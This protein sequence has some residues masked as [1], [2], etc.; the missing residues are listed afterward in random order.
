MPTGAQSTAL[1]RAVLCF[2]SHCQR[3]QDLYEAC[4]KY[5]QPIA[6][7]FVPHFVPTLMPGRATLVGG[8]SALPDCGTTDCCPQ[9]L[10]EGADCA[11]RRAERVAASETVFD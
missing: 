11:Q 10:R 5:L 3:K 6:K 8:R 9:R 7:P 2:W 1:A 4:T